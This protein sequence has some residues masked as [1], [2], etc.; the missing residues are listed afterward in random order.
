MYT[1][2]CVATCFPSFELHPRLFYL[3]T[4]ELWC[5]MACRGEAAPHVTGWTDAYPNI[6]TITGFGYYSLQTDDD[7]D[8]PDLVAL[9][10]PRT[11]DEE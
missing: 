10:V 9:P 6:H 11:Y 4:F 2:P 5:W 1:I 3:L 7:D 8:S